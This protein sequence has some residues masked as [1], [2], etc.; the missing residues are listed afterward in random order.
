M[1]DALDALERIATLLE[2]F[3]ERLAILTERVAALEDDRPQ[4]IGKQAAAL[5]RIEALGLAKPEA[6]KA[7]EALAEN[8]AATPAAFPPEWQQMDETQQRAWIS[9][10]TGLIQ[11]TEQPEVETIQM[12]GGVGGEF[13]AAPQEIKD[14]WRDMAEG[15]FEN[16]V[17]DIKHGITIGKEQAADAYAQA[18]PLWL[19][20]YAHD[21]LMGLPYNWRQQMVDQVLKYAPVNAKYLGRDILRVPT[22]GAKTW[23]YDDALDVADERLTGNVRGVGTQMRN[24]SG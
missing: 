7:I 1:A 13:P 4:N 2:A 20:A 8:D 23:A 3:D 14:A 16:W 24:P 22:D 19:A 15:I 21:F 10:H 11:K 12:E 9:A 17:V 6:G 5:A 18:G